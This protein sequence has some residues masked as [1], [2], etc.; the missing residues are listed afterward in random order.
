M[1]VH[2]AP[3]IVVREDRAV[4]G[5]LARDPSG[6]QVP[7]EGPGPGKGARRYHRVGRGCRGRSE[8][9]QCVREVP[10]QGHALFLLRLRR[11]RRY[12]KP[13][14][15]GVHVAPAEASKLTAAKSGARGQGIHES[16]GA[17]LLAEAPLLG[18]RHP[19]EA[20]ARPGV[21]Q[22]PPRGCP[23]QAWQAPRPRGPGAPA[24]GPSPRSAVGASRR[25]REPACGT[26]Q[27][28]G[29]TGGG[30]DTAC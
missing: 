8:G 17:P 29:R 7:L 4:L 3:L 13:E 12:A 11:A 16:P 5:L 21:L 14:R 18:L 9:G 6:Q 28:S 10:A 30:P 26:S 15:L 27:A 24:C 25:G 23:D 1:E 2:H 20:P 22:G 19:L